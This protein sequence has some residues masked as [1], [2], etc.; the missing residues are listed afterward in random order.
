MTGI[1]KIIKERTKAQGP[2]LPIDL[3][4]R[5]VQVEPAERQELHRMMKKQRTQAQ[6][7]QDEIP[8]M[9]KPGTSR[10]YYLFVED[11]AG[12]M[13]EQHSG[14]AIQ[15]T[16]TKQHLPTDLITKVEAT[17]YQVPEQDNPIDD[18]DAETISS[19]ST[20]DY[21]CEEVE[22]SLTTTSEAFRMIAYEKLMTTVPHM[23]KIQAAQV[24]AKLPILPIQKQEMKMEKT[25]TAKAIKNEPVPGTSTEWP[26][27]EA[28]EPME[29]PMEKAMEESTSTKKDDKPEEESI[30]EYFRRYVLT[31]KGKS[32]ED[33]IQEACKEINYQNLVVLIAVGDYIMNQAKNIKEVAKK[34][35]LSFSAVQRAMSRKR[36][37]SV[38]GRQYAKWKKDAERQEGSPKKSKWTGK[39]GTSGSTEIRSPPH[40]EPNQDSSDSTELPDVPWVHT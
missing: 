7:K 22:V 13:I 8:R 16:D 2:G 9:D 18:D 30:S 20:A 5:N 23:S 11:D 29:E 32:P 35:G 25:E 28:E 39:K 1:S 19:T 38:G 10:G 37:H 31:G 26:T 12:C 34:W 15:D 6:M 3:I 36:E 4:E 21:D 40:M 14:Q 33:K 24:I 17:T 27:A